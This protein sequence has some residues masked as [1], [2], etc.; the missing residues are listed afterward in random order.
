IASG[1]FGDGAAAVVLTG[2]ERAG[3]GPV[4]VA[5]RSAFYPGTEEVMGWRVGDSGFRIV[6]SAEVPGMVRKYLRRDLDAFLAD[7]AL[8]YDDIAVWIAHP[9]GPKVLQA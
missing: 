6:L 9:G 2:A 5:T 3:Q 1:L 4:I 8:T 7:Q